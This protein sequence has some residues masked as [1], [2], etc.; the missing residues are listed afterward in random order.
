MKPSFL[1]KTNLSLSLSLSLSVSAVRTTDIPRLTIVT[2][3][4]AR[5]KSRLECTCGQLYMC[6]PGS[7]VV[8]QTLTHWN[9]NGCSMTVPP[10]V[11]SPSS[12]LPPPSSHCAF[13][14]T[15]YNSERILKKAAISFLFCLFNTVFLKS[16]SWNFVR[17]GTP[18]VTRVLGL[19]P[20]RSVFHEVNNA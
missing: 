8:I 2:F 4:T 5:R 6:V 19:L 14:P 10:P 20:I 13:T 16:E 3:R 9:P 11:L 15:R 7:P 17:R 18:A 12:I 1:C